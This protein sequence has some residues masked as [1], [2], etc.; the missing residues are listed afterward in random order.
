MNRN[1]FFPTILVISGHYF[2]KLHRNGGVCTKGGLWVIV[3]GELIGMLGLLRSV[4]DYC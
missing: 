1:D 2:V 3:S 4:V